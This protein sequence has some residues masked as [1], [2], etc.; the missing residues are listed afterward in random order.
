MRR[1]PGGGALT[2]VDAALDTVLAM[3]APVAGVET[4]PLAAAAGRALAEDVTTPIP[5]P[6]FDQIGR[7]HV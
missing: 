2:P 3:A 4:V 6:P 7:A 5:L 1:R